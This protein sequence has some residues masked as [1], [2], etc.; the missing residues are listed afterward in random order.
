MNVTPTIS[1]VMPCHDAAAHLGEAL[2]S[3]R[4]QTWTGWELLVVDD[5]STDD[6]AAIAMASGDRRIRLLRRSVAGGPAAARNM[7]LDAARGDWIALLDAD[8]MMAPD[9]LA[10]LLHAA[11]AEAATIVADD[12]VLFDD[13]GGFAPHR[14]VGHDAPR[15]VDAAGWA[16]ANRPFGR[17][18]Q[19]GYLKPL[20]RRTLL[21]YDETLRVGEDFDLIQ[22]MLGR[23]GR[24]LLLPWAGYFYRRHGASISHRLPAGSLAAMRRADAALPRPSP[25]IAAALDARG[26]AIDTALAVEAAVQALKARRL[27]APPPAAWPILARFAWQALARRLPRRT[28]PTA[29]PGICVISRQ[30][31]TPRGNGSS[32][33]LVSLCQALRADGFAVHLIS[34]TPGSFGRMPALRLDGLEGAFDSMAFRGGVRLG[35]W[36]VATSPTPLLRAGL[37]M[38]ARALAR[39]RLPSPAPWRRPAPYA[40]A[41]PWTEDDLLF[42]ARQAQRRAV[43]V[44][45]D[46]AFC[47]PAAGHALA[48]EAPVAVLLHDLLSERARSFARDGASDSVAVLDA[49]GES[50]LLAQADIVIAIQAEEAAAA[51]RL[52][53]TGAAEVV[54]APMAASPVA[55]PQPG[56]GGGLLFV[57]SATQP[58]VDGMRWFLA[59]V[60]PGLHARRP[61]LGLTVAG[62]VAGALPATPGVQL[63]GRVDDLAPLYRAADVVISP[64]RAGSGLK[65]K[66]VEALAAGKAVVA[67]PATLQGVPDAPVALADTPAEFAAAIEALLDDPEARAALAARAL[68]AAHTRF[69]AGPAYGPLIAALRRRLGQAERAPALAA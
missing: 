1:V 53:P 65:I 54:V 33:Y 58:N 15:W 43:A 5:G 47:L 28:P 17:G 50:A 24:L 61:G 32:A 10:R 62:H 48:P 55:A 11:E 56:E 68:Q 64:L 40:M 31:I 27:P 35:N 41:L 57:G 34:P 51:R 13:A 3:L 18:A 23:D 36:L 39:L 69:A 21:R 7:A 37:E 16:L 9:R 8:D 59:E 44:L 63:V 38:A 46:Y 12:L 30:R 19:L 67:S 29:A 45:A 2:A 6:S 14:L 52:L 49:A 26:R 60:W 22:R 42:V 25:A 66:L 20:F 4:R